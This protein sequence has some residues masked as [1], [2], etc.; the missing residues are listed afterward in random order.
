MFPQSSNPHL[1]PHAIEITS[2]AALDSSVDDHKAEGARTA[3]YN[4]MIADLEETLKKSLGD[5]YSNPKV[6]AQSLEPE[7]QKRKRR[8]LEGGPEAADSCL[9][10]DSLPF[11]LVSHSLPPKPVLLQPEPTPV[12]I[13]KEPPCEDTDFEA[14]RRTLQA[15]AVAVD[16][17]WVLAESKEAYPGA[18]ENIIHVDIPSLTSDPPAMM[19]A[20]RGKPPHRK[21]KILGSMS[22][23]EGKPSPH[24]LPAAV[25]CPTFDIVTASQDSSPQS[26]KRR[27][28]KLASSRSKPPAMNG[29]KSASLEYAARGFEGSWPVAANDLR[30]YSYQRDRM[31]KGIMAGEQQS[32]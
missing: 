1:L 29:A 24:S 20:E 15:Q 3:E 31:R 5:V 7:S 22:P 18:K 21:P 10:T 28:R 14:T 17:S 30:R 6:L 32:W 4:Q 25:C 2:R 13:A 19:I 23:F 8:R 12:I 11:R 9:L 16:F 26:N 27:R